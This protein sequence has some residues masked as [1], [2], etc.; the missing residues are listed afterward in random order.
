MG[1]ENV[2]S[3]GWPRTCE[4]GDPFFRRGQSGGWGGGV[5]LDRGVMYTLNIK[6][7]EGETF[8]TA[9]NEIVSLIFLDAENPD[10]FKMGV[11]IK[12]GTPPSR[13]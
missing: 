11:R 3:N 4:R 8:S 2:I 1:S 12:A 7:Q 6:W 13:N 5:I 9:L 10:C